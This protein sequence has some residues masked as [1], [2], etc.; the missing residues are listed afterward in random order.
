MYPRDLTGKIVSKLDAREIIILLGT[1]QTGKTTLTKLVAEAS[2]FDKEHIFFFDLEDKEYRALFNLEG[3][4]VNTLKNILQIEGVRTDEKNLVIFDEI[5]HLADPSN[6]LK[7]LY[8]YFEEIKVI[9]TGS[10]SLKI[11]H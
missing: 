6:L 7:L 9:A 11:K 1:R 8:D 4:G 10:S 2:D 3:L 5:Q